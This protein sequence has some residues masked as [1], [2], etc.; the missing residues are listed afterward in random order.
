MTSSE[1]RGPSELY[2]FYMY[3]HQHLYAAGSMKPKYH[4]VKHN[5]GVTKNIY[6]LRTISVNINFHLR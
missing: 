6:R 2:L 1:S 5:T 4:H 3:Y